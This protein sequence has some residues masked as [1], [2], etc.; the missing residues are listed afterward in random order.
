M[1]KSNIIFLH[2]WLFDSRIWYKLPEM[3]N[4]QYN[5]EI[6]DLPGY[7]TNKNDI[8]SH[9]NYCL[10]IFSR[11][12]PCFVVAYSYS[13]LLAL[14]AISNPQ[15]NIRKMILINSKFDSSTNNDQLINQENIN[16]LIKSLDIDRVGAI[17]KFMFECTR[18]SQTSKSDYKNII[19]IFDV[20]SLPSNEILKSNLMYMNKFKPMTITNNLY[21]KILSI[22]SNN[23]KL[24]GESSVTPEN[25][26]II[27]Y[28][29]DGLGHIP[30]INGSQK[31]Y[32]I[33]KR[34]LEV[35]RKI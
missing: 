19:E 32:T 25:K 4:N 13:G 18:Y 8:Q 28:H 11:N 17:K 31:I 3:F 20:D 16:N 21:D 24:I 33:I 12:E 23:D 35:E 29:L 30:F 22:V 5:I 1:H 10:K 34:F 7:G 14:N 6:H 2:G 26:N 9:E 15:C 27:K